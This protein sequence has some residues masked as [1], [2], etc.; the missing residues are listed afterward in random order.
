[1]GK[2][3]E[4]WRLGATELGR[5]YRDGSLTPLEALLSCLARIDAVQPAINAFVAQ[6]RDQVLAEARASGERH[7]AGRPLSELD[8]IPLSIKDNLL[9]CDMPTTWG[10]PALRDHR[11]AQDELPVARARSAGALIVGK[12]NVPEF[13]LEGYTSNALF[14]VTRNPWNLAL[15]P[16]GS[17]GAAAA[18]V[19]AGCTPLALCTDG[20]GS[21]RRP[22]CHAGLVGFKP[23]IGAVARNWTLPS[24]LLDF[25]VVGPMARSVADARLLFDVVRGPDA[26]DRRSLAADAAARSHR[27]PRALN[28]LYVPVIAGP[29][30]AAPVDREVAASCELAA[31]RLGALGHS[32]AIGTLP[33]DL[34]LMAECWPIIGQ[35]GLDWM[36]QRQ[37]QWR[38]G[39]SQKYLEMAAQ[40]AGLPAWRLW[41]VLEAVEQF[42]RDCGAL[43]DQYDVVITPAAAAL[44]WPADQA[45]PAVIDRQAVGPRGHAVFTGWVNAA[46]LPA[47]AVPADPSFSG[48]PIGIQM[49]AAFGAD[50][51]LF[52]LAAAY[53]DRHPWRPRWP[54]L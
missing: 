7:A 23:S 45:F 18:S 52:D 53:E 27:T 47:I 20:G 13:T 26:A 36:F 25:E 31:R 17:S 15:T 19:T 51:M 32:L 14:G 1:M 49:V 42:R 41:E 30:G 22:A 16:G 39:A 38:E 24:L 34:G 6:R 21:I 8:G 48:L 54:E 29:A 35:I 28:L 5:C 46:G 43:F 10:C 11:S 3:N 44:P 37:P 4:P 9:T 2:P 40:G 33:L 12:T 50:Q